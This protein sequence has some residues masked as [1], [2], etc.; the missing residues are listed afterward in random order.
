[1]GKRRP[2]LMDE[3]VKH[4]LNEWGGESERK[5]MVLGM[6]ELKMD[7]L[8]QT[9]DGRSSGWIHRDGLRMEQT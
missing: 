5:G 7:S 3:E 4:L 1:V 8:R 6:N 2:G 9:S